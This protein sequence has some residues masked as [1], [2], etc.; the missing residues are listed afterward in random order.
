MPVRDATVTIFFLFN[1]FPPCVC[2][3]RGLLYLTRIGI[4]LR[5]IIELMVAVVIDEYDIHA[6]VS[7]LLIHQ[8]F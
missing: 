1:Y 5:F 4:L 7:S 8:G 6:L 2:L 3:F